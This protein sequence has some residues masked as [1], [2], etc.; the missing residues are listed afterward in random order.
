[1]TEPVSDEHSSLNLDPNL[2]GALC[3]AFGCI[4]GLLFFILE[5]HSKQIRFHALQSILIFALLSFLSVVSA[6]LAVFT[7]FVPFQLATSLLWMIHFTVWLVMIIRTYQGTTI[8]I[9]G[10][11]DFAREQTGWPA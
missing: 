8:K 2:A 11:G 3:Y 10:I 9:P 5:T 4:S 1:M 6:V 7:D